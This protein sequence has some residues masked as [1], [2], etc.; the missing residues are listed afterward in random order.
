[1][2]DNSFTFTSYVPEITE[3]FVMLKNQWLEESASEIE[4]DAKEL[5]IPDT[6]QTKSHYSHIVYPSQNKAQVGNTL[7]NAVYEEFGTGEYAM[8]GKGR[9]GYWV[10]VKGSNG[11][12]YE[13]STP[14][15]YYTLAQAKRIMRYLRSKGLEAYYTKGK[16]PRRPLYRAFFNGRKKIE[17]GFRYKMR[18]L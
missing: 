2:A 3:R 15:K 5:S 13:S 17:R 11:T 18:S 4:R 9:K 10:Y 1:M 12:D 8:N 16:H 6:G 14:R 7:M